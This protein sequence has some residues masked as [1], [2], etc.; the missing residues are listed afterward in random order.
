MLID[1][2]N[3]GKQ[4]GT[5]YH[6]TNSESLSDILKSNTLEATYGDYGKTSHKAISGAS[7]SFTRSPNRNNFPLAVDSD[8]V[9]VIDGNKLSNNYKIIPYSEQEAEFDE[10]EERIYNK[11]ISIL[12]KR[13]NED[14]KKKTPALNKPKRGGSKKFYVYVRDPKSKRVKKVSFGMAGNR[15]FERLPQ[16]RRCS[17]MCARD[18]RSCKP[19]RAR[20]Q[21]RGG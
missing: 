7:I 20:P 4:V 6:F 12:Q 16:R 8:C 3:E 19:R 17:A 13:L 2:L 14:D 10:M 21:T 18:M 5:L 1:L 15:P 9:L 11:Y